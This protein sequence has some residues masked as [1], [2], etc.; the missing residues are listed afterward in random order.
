MYTNVVFVFH[1]KI[2]ILNPL[3]NVYEV[4]ENEFVNNFEL[5]I[6]FHML[7]TLFIKK[8]YHAWLIEN[9]FL[10]FIYLRIV[11]LLFNIFV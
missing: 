11:P 1:F 10:I 4:F 8:Q 9:I 2:K 3:N 5:S 7:F 6:N